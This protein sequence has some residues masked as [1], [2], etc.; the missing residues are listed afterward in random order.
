MA[1]LTAVLGLTLCFTPLAPIGFVMV[2]LGSVFALRGSTI[3]RF[4]VGFVIADVVLLAG[5]GFQA[6]PTT[7]SGP[8][9]AAATGDDN[10]AILRR[11]VLGVDYPCDDVVRTFHRG[12]HDGDDVWSLSCANGRSYSVRRQSS[13]QYQV[14]TCEIVASITHDDCFSAFKR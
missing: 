3:K 14:L 10:A 5:M 7:S 11:A 4:G 1:I 9:P 13:G 12:S 2:W 6:G 8:R